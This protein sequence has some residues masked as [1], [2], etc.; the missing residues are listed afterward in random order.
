MVSQVILSWLCLVALTQAMV[1]IIQDPTVWIKSAAGASCETT[2]QARGGCKEDAWP[3]TLEEFQEILDESGL[4]CVSI[5]QGG[6]KYDPST[7]GRYCGWHGDPG[8][9]SRSRCAAS[10]DAGTYRFCPCFGDKEL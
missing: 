4:K 2:C 8:E 9:G 10:G 1:E 6:A 5:Q 7:D 3:A